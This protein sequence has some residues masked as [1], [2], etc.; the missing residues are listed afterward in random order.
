MEENLEGRAAGIVAILNLLAEFAFA[1]P[2]GAGDRET[3][4]GILLFTRS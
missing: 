4:K 2:A 3:G 1:D